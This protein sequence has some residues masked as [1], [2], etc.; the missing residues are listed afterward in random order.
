MSDQ[1]LAEEL[2]KPVIGKFKKWKVRSI[3]ID[4]IW[5]ADLADMQIISKFN[6]G[7]TFSIPMGNFLKR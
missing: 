4:N 1:Q 2:H 5:G 6:K 3:F 7:F